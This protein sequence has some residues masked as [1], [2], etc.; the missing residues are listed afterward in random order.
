M[1]KV[2]LINSIHRNYVKNGIGKYEELRVLKTNG[3]GFS[4]TWL[5]GNQILQVGEYMIPIQN[6]AG[7]EKIE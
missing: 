4:L 3:N 6:I 7:I 2:Y 1:Y 5:N